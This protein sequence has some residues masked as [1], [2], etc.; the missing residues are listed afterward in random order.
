MVLQTIKLP[1]SKFTRKDADDWIK[2][3][4]YKVRYRGKKDSS[5]LYFRYRQVEPDKSRKYYSKK[6]PN[7]VILTFY[8]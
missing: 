8:E 5:K 3:H 7:G 4:K 6:L 1:K 2:K